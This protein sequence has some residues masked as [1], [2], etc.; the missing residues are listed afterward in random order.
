MPE[1]LS[2][3]EI[4][5]FIVSKLSW[6]HKHSQRYKSIEKQGDCE[7]LTDETH[8]FL[9]NKY[10]LHIIETTGRQHVELNT[11]YMVLYV[12]AGSTVEKRKK[13]LLEFYR[14]NLK[15]IIPSYIDKW[16]NILNVNV[17]DFGIKLMKTR[18][19]TCNTRD[20]RIWV[21][22]ELAKKAPKY[23]EYI[24]VHEM[25]HLLERYHNQ[26]FKNYMN[27]LLPEWKKIKNELNG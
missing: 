26:N 25:V 18:W 10:K 7:F 20:K 8:Y 17:N 15:K 19:G 24:I 27:K 11:E 3:E 14:Q 4:R 21:N 23:L 22:L 2:D 6:I 5:I 13:I 9:G 12:R 16:E 1:Y